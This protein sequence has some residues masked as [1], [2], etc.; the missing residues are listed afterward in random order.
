MNLL[1]MISTIIYTSFFIGAWINMTAERKSVLNLSA[2]AVLISLGWWSF[3]NSFFFAAATLEQAWFW[4][5]FSSVGWCG[6]VSFTAYY[7]LAL[8]SYNKQNITLCKQALFFLPTVILIV[9]NLFGTTTCL[10]QNLVPL[11]N[12]MGW[13]YENSPFSFWLWAYLAYVAVYFGVAFILLYRWAKSTKHKM[14]R[15]MALV[16]IVLDTITIL[17]GVITDVILP[18]SGNLFPPLASVATAFFGVG[19]FAI[20]YRYDVFNI[21]LV[22]SPNDILQI[23]NNSIFVMDENNEILRYNHAVDSLLGYNKSELMGKDFMSLISNDIDLNP[24]Y[25]GENLTD[26]ETRLR[27]KDGTIKDVLFSASVAKDKLNSFLCTIV[28]C[29]DV[30]KQK[31]VQQELQVERENYKQLANDYHLLAYF[32][33]LTGLANRRQFFDVLSDFEKRYAAEQKDF[34]VIFLD[35]D[36]FKQ[37]NDFYGHKGGDEVLV[38]AANKLKACTANG[39]FVARI[40]GDEFMVILPCSQTEETVQKIAAIKCE[41][42]KIIFL[43][44]A[45]YEIGISAGYSSFS[46]SKDITKLMQKADEGMYQNKKSLSTH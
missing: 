36:N 16:F 15:E 9:K 11:A 45:P 14:K 25:N 42:S 5:K 46:Q 38:A 29:Q 21:N 24:L 39:E 17:L 30:S 43:G 8:T 19:Y 33:P 34:A 18:I 20:I 1:S 31:K 26:I 6:F 37:V 23:S 40:G 44:K 13:T 12:G 2:G 27:C 10:A 35:L 3:C 28:S 7:F 22:I 41:F 4:H 32:D